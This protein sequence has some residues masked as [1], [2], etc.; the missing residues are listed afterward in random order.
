MAPT[1]STEKKSDIEAGEVELPPQLSAT[2]TGAVMPATGL[3]VLVS[4]SVSWP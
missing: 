2:P 3:A 4:T 1:S